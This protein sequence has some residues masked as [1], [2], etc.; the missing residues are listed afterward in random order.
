LKGHISGNLSEKCDF[1]WAEIYY[2]HY[3]TTWGW[4]YSRTD[5]I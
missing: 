2:F 4:E 3:P 5:E 1:L